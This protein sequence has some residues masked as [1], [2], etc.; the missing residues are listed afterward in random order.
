M[1]VLPVGCYVRCPIDFDSRLHREYILGQVYRVDSSK[2]GVTVKFHD[3]NGMRYFYEDIPASREYSLKEVSRCD[4]LPGSIVQIR[5]KALGNKGTSAKAMVLAK[6]SGDASNYKAYYVQ[7]LDDSDKK[8]VLLLPEKVLVANFTRADYNP[9]YQLLNYELHNPFWFKKRMEVSEYLSI[10]ENGPAGLKILL[11][12]RAHLYAH[13]IDTI[14]SALRKSRCRIILADEVGLGK[15]IEAIVIMTG[16]LQRYD[17]R[18]RALVLVPDTLVNQWLNELDIKFWLDAFVWEG[19]GFD[20]KRIV[21]LPHSKL[22]EFCETGGFEA[23]D[24][25]LCIVDEA[26]KLLQDALSYFYLKELSA[27]IEHLILITATPIKEKIKELYEL[28]VLLDPRKYAF[29]SEEDFERVMK[30]QTQIE[31]SLYFWKNDLAYL[32]EHG[33]LH[34]QYKQQLSEFEGE[35]LHDPGL[36][37]K[38]DGLSDQPSRDN[39]EKIRN[40]LS[41]ITD[42]YRFSEFIFMHRRDDMNHI[43][44]K[45][46]LEDVIYY[47]TAS[48]ADGVYERETYESLLEY[49]DLFFKGEN[50]PDH[51]AVEF[52]KYVLGAAF[53]SPFALRRVLEERLSYLRKEGCELEI[54]SGVDAVQG[55]SGRIDTVMGFLGKW[56]KAVENE[57]ENVQELYDNPFDIKSRLGLAFD[58]IAQN[59][60]DKKVLVFSHYSETVKAFHRMMRNFFGDSKVAI[61]H[62]G[63]DMDEME[64]AAVRFQTDPGCCFMLCDELGGEGRNF[65]VADAIVHIDLPFYPSIIEQRI[66][67]LDRIGREPE[68]DVASIVICSKDTNEE[69]MFRILNDALDIFNKSVSGLEIVLDDI[70]RE[71]NKALWKDIRYGLVDLCESIREFYQKVAERLEFEVLFDANKKLDAFTAE[72][73]EEIINR[74]D[75]DGAKRISQTMLSWAESIG[76]YEGEENYLKRDIIRFDAG[77]FSRKYKSARNSLYCPTFDCE[78]LLSR[79][80]KENVIEGTFLREL[81]IKD[82]S[83]IFFAPTNQ[84]FESIIENARECARG[85]CTA[86]LQFNDRVNWCGFAFN[87]LIMPNQRSLLR[88]G[89][90]QY[91]DHVRGYIKKG[92]LPIFVPLIEILTEDEMYVLSTRANIVIDRDVDGEELFELMKLYDRNRIV[93]LGRRN[94]S[95]NGYDIR[96]FAAIFGPPLW[97]Q[98]VKRAYDSAKTRL[99]EEIGYYIN[100]RDAE[101]NLD[102]LII[103]EDISLDHKELL[104]ECL[105][106][107][108]ISLDSAVFCW[109]VKEDE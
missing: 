7:I 33:E 29:L 104:L 46:A 70:Q 50:E 26:H 60:F 86:F 109:L 44:P 54:I 107:P 30:A 71:I 27:E 5:E 77:T 4:I 11:G 83:L 98:M 88:N 69:Q 59:L 45:R 80:K 32:K 84:F 23:A 1:E 93:H 105:R 20:S 21:V 16:L 14:V 25:K 63:M 64:E 38:I 92:V 95:K 103:S 62:R 40:I 49:L 55:E 43:M 56:E 28:V 96:K 18:A 47:D 100:L 19:Y 48:S 57:I 52:A 10:V 58:Y 31:E 85:R 9:V 51:E 39:V 94:E 41:Y 67:R 66:G 2:G 65:Q 53:S 82:E 37:E 61:F 87:F 79:T 17:Q 75:R 91:F 81:A 72:R 68:R 74:F 108:Q 101:E 24:Y 106:S 22:K 36:K 15:T 35:I 34:A 42:K 3:L 78:K 6:A 89:I 13:Q 12:S 76:F 8:D 90:P 73:I 97:R 99:K 102:K